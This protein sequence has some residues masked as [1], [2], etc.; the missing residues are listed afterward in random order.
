MDAVARIRTARRLVV[1]IGS[2]LLV[3]DR[4]GQLNSAWLTGLVEDF[5]ELKSAGGDVLVVSSGAIALGRRVLGMGSGLLSLEESQAA[6]AVGQIRLARAYE[7]S[8]VPHGLVAAQVLLTLDDSEDRRRYLNSRATLQSLLRRNVIPVINENDTIATDEIR[9]GDN[10]RLA[11]Q[12]AVMTNSDLLVLFSDV[13]G[14]YDRD[15]RKSRNAQLVSTITEISTHINQMADDAATITSKG[16]MKTKVMAARTVTRAGCAMIIARG[17]RDRPLRALSEGAPC[18]LFQPQGDPKTARRLWIGSMKT[19][20]ELVV[21]QGAARALNSGKSLLPAGVKGV[22]GEFTRGEPVAI[23]VEDGALLGQ[24]LVR[25]NCNE[26]RLIHGRKSA[27]IADIL[28]Y[29]ARSAMVHRDD[30]AL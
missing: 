6:A 12:V 18:T 2:S 11:A 9:F 3:D 30:M 4:S 19:R 24:G 15:P 26:A 21:D 29:P 20:G 1:K 10:D 13:D 23:L 7:E 5:A 17:G 28:G 25:Y 8:L 27:E 22:N 16:G 14:L